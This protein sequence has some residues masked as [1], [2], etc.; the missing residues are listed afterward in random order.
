MG[1][2]SWLDRVDRGLKKMR[3]IDSI[4]IRNSWN[5]IYEDRHKH[6]DEIISG[7][8]FPHTTKGYAIVDRNGMR[9]V[10]SPLARSWSFAYLQP[11]SIESHN[12]HG[13]IHGS[14]SAVSDGIVDLLQVLRR[15]NSAGMMQHVKEFVVFEYS[16]TLGRVSPY[17]F[18]N[19]TDIHI[20]FKSLS[21]NLRVLDLKFAPCIMEPAR[22]PMLDLQ[23]FK[24]FLEAAQCL[25]SMRLFL[26]CTEDGFEARDVHSLYHFALVFPEGLTWNLPCLRELMLHGL[27]ASYSELVTLLFLNCPKLDYLGLSYFQLKDGH[28]ED[29]I[30]GLRRI[31]NF[32]DFNSSEKGLLCSTNGLFHIWADTEERYEDGEWGFSELISEYISDGGR[33]PCLARDAPDSASTKYMDRLNETLDKLCLATS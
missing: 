31:P 33:H 4:T 5:M 22:Q 32:V 6:P 15:I 23:I 21:S 17:A 7:F 3:S 9:L 29:I 1:A 8:M 18:P 19:N 24:R 28:W 16:G 14:P 10:G 27:R 30:E 26:P 12:Y 13:P 2:A 20:Q 11:Q 25:E